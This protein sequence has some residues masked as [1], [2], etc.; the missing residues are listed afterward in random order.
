[1]VFI[2]WLKW[3]FSARLECK[4]SDL[5]LN[6]CNFNKNGVFYKNNIRYKITNC[7]FLDEP[8]NN[9]PIVDI[10]TNSGLELRNYTGALFISTNP[11]IDYVD[12][13]DEK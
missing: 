4:L 5:I 6:G 13:I 1:M 8:N 9:A 3:V 10:N 11:T 12:I 7:L 2:D